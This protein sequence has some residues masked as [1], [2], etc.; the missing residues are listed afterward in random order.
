MRKIGVRLVAGPLTKLGSSPTGT[1]TLRSFLEP[2]RN[3]STLEGS[4]SLSASASH[5][6]PQMVDKQ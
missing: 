6:L 2:T 1:L 5:C 4:F 3:R